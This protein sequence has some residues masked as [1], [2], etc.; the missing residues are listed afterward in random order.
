MHVYED[1]DEFADDGAPDALAATLPDWA[2]HGEQGRR[3]CHEL[4]HIDEVCALRG[5]PLET[6]A[7]IASGVLPAARDVGPW[8]AR[9]AGRIVN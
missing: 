9:P 1:Y 8:V 4:A 2:V 5:R 3:S 7:G 6:K